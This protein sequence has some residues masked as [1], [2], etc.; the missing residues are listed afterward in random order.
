MKCFQ[1][2]E[3]GT[4]TTS[5]LFHTKLKT[6]YGTV[7]KNQVAVSRDQFFHFETSPAFSWMKPSFIKQ[8]SCP[9]NWKLTQ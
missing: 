4:L 7:F 8:E 9:D 2:L 5:G 6:W 1:R 3:T